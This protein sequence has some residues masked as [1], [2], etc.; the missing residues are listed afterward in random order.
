MLP[1]EIWVSVY[2]CSP[3]IHMIVNHAPSGH[4]VEGVSEPG[5][6]ESELR[7]RLLRQLEAQLEG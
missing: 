5:E 6:R 7:A 4:R 3:N 2:K 1:S